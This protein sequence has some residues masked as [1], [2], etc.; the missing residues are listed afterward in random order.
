MSGTL[1]GSAGVSFK[2]M[3]VL[4]S[5]ALVYL[6]AGGGTY[7]LQG[8]A[9]RVCR[10]GDILVVFPEIAHGYGPPPGGSWDEIY[11]VFE[12]PVFDVWRR[13]GL[14][15][16]GH[17]ILRPH[18]FSDHVEKLREIVELT[19]SATDPAVQ[20]EAVCALQAFMA[21]VL[22]SDKHKSNYKAFSAKPAWL[23]AVVKKMAEN[24]TEPLQEVAVSCGLSYETFRKQFRELTGEA[25][26]HFRT[27]QRFL[28]AQKLIYED[29][30]STKE[31][32]DRLGFCDEFHFSKRFR[33]VTGQTPGA[34]R[35]SL[36]TP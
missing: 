9:P 8:S 35:R 11:I 20:L 2:S 32:A 30:L 12:G 17:P 26:A 16:P 4:G 24:P 29:R 5:Y 10:A 25:P 14:L 23:E 34:F 36:T 27:R 31:V 13:G 3:R 28:L 7:Q 21:S 19:A 15:D 33:E 1:L 18:P 22:L 6:T